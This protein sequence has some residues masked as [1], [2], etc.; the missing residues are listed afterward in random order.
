M[1]HDVSPHCVIAELTCR[2]NKDVIDSVTA[3]FCGQCTSLGFTCM[4]PVK[5][6]NKPWCENDSTRCDWMPLTHPGF[7]PGIWPWNR[8]WSSARSG[9]SAGLPEQSSC[10]CPA[11]PPWEARVPIAGLPGHKERRAA[12]YIH[13]R[14][15]MK[16]CCSSTNQSGALDPHASKD[17]LDQPAVEPPPNWF[18]DKPWLWLFKIVSLASLA[19]HLARFKL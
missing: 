7:S 17:V 8:S 12:R 9:S 10:P 15:H 4:L 19:C 2:D 3:L 5:K 14:M 13:S 11:S 18:L 16:C 1:S 6:I